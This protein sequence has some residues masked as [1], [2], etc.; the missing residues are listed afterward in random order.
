ME[1]VLIFQQRLHWLFARHYDLCS[2]I[3]RHIIIQ[4]KVT[5]IP[6]Q[7]YV[8]IEDWRNLVAHIV[9]KNSKYFLFYFTHILHI[10]IYF[11]NTSTQ[12]RNIL[13]INPIPL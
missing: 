8:K 12:P 2:D 7:P 4:A 11:F 6:F 10:E 9:T 13:Y 5:F 1:P 3:S